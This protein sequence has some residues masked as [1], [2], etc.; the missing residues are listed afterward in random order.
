MMEGHY[1]PP[2]P[3]D[4]DVVVERERT[5]SSTNVNKDGFIATV[6][7]YFNFGGPGKEEEEHVNEAD[8]REQ[9]F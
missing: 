5:I 1:P 9:D 3:T 4:N 7:K 6:G 2:P 8:D